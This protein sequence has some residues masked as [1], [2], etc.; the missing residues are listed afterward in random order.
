M[1]GLAELGEFGL[2]DQIRARFPQPV[3]PELGI[4]DDAALLSPS[5]GSQVVVSTD[6]L[7]EGVHFDLGFGPARLL[8]RKS[9]AVN[10]SDIASMGAVPRWFFLSL[11]IPAGFPLE[12]IEGLLDGLAEQAAEYG[13][14]LAGGDTCGSKSG[15]V[16]SVT[17]MGEQRPELILKRSGAVLDDEVWVSGSLGDS[18]LGLQLLMEGKRLGQ[19]DDYLMQRQLDPTPRCDLGRKLAEAGLVNAMIDISDGLLADLGHIGE[20]SGCGAEIQLGQLLLSPAFQAYAANQHAFPW[21]LAVSGGEDYELCFTAPVCNHGAIQKISKTTGIPLT[22]I[23]KITSSRQV[24]AILPDG[25]NFQ[26]SASG[27]THF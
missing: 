2:I 25:T 18:A 23:G 19:S 3:A 22:V 5:A 26:P 4:G 1:K 21:Q 24:Q 17:I 8:G 6:L 10:L 14:I 11:A 7:A 9:L 12:T 27:Y 15:L 13:C 20:Q 16:I